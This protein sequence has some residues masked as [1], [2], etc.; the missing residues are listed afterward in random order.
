MW[1]EYFNSLP[2]GELVINRHGKELQYIVEYLDQ[3]L[4]Q[5]WEVTKWIWFEEVKK[6]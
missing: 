1:K 4:D 5:T 2:E 6:P 3:S